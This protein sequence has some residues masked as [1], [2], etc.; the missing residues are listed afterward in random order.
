MGDLIQ[1]STSLSDFLEL[2]DLKSEELA[3]V[4]QEPTLFDFTQSGSKPFFL[5]TLL[6]GNETSGW[7]ALRAITKEVVNEHGLPSVL[8]L[9]GNVKAAERNRRHLDHQPDFNRIW[10]DGDSPY[11]RWASEILFYVRARQPWFSLDIHNNTG[12]NPH[13]TVLTSLDELTLRAARLFS[14]TAI[15]ARQ[16]PGVLTR[17]CAEFST[18]T[19]IE[20]GLPQD[21]NS[22][23]RARSYLE[24]LWRKQSV[25]EVDTSDLNIFENSVRVI[26]ENAAQLTN[27]DVPQFT[28]KLH[29]YNFKVI[30]AGTTLAKLSSSDVRLLAIDKYQQD[31]T[32]DYLRYIN[33]TVELCR[34]TIMSMYTED[35]LIIR[36]DCVCYFL[37]VLKGYHA[38]EFQPDA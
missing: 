4:I 37:D 23:R 2:L 26:V 36:Q 14:R 25:P 12:P 18:A 28:P 35:P 6:H 10:D 19:T 34:D 11:Q 24:K 5:S 27:D 9:L 3:G 8:I 31:R 33:G 20:A 21:P 16:P 22:A 30:P 38:T 13:H 17:R 7:D 15:V 32:D 29:Q 1:V